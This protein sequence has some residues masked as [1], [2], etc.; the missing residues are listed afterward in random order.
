MPYAP[1]PCAWVPR[2]RRL[3]YVDDYVYIED[4]SIA[5][6]QTMPMT[7][8]MSNNNCKWRQVFINIILPKGL[9]MEKIDPE[10]VDPEAFTF[11]YIDYV[12]SRDYMA[13]SREFTDSSYMDQSYLNALE[14]ESQEVGY[15]LETLVEVYLGISDKVYIHI[16]SDNRTGHN[17]VYPLA[18]FRIRATEELE[19]NAVI[20]TRAMFNDNMLGQDVDNQFEGTP[21]ECRVH[22]VVDPEVN[23]DVNGDGTVDIDD[24]NI[25]VNEMLRK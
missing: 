10:E 24:V 6:G 3:K 13:L 22:L 21:K 11:A 25:V 1:P 5:P 20:T 23:A 14:W 12:H 2:V 15:D 8:W 16:D 17:G 4:F 19:D 9:V 7:L 18:Q